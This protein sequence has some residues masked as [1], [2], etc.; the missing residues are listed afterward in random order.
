MFESAVCH[1][2]FYIFAVLAILSALGVFMSRNSVASALCMA[3]CFAFTAAILFGMGA[4][5][6]GVAQLI[7]YAGAILVLFLF[8]VMMLDVKTEEKTEFSWKRLILGPLV[9]GAF[10]GVVTLIALNFPGA[11]GES[12][13]LGK[14]PS[15][16]I[17]GES[18]SVGAYGSNLPKLDAVKANLLANPGM[19]KDQ[20]TS[21][22]SYPD[23]KLL[24]M[25]LF[26]RYGLHFAIL[27]FALLAG[28]VGAVALARK[29]R[30][31]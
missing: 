8:I 11:S 28:S 25:C 16:A 10:A 1:I 27:S 5:F 21:V 2:L 12:C 14:M 18:A 13:C 15:V 24:G 31:D 6:L 20:A 26:N 19:K 7:V 9:A 17:R 3:L 30:K 23:T 4:Q 29:I 22:R